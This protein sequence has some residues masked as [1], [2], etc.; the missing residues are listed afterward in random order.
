MAKS[1]TVIPASRIDEKKETK[2]RKIRVAAYCR[3]STDHEEQAGSFQNQVKYYTELIRKNLDWECAGIFADEGISGTDVRKRTGF[4][5]MI[6]ACRAGQVDLVITKSISR[7]A[8]N[9][10]D[11]LRY[12]RELKDRGIGIRFE[13]E[14]VDT[15]ASSGELLFTILSSLA[16]EESRNISENTRW[17]IRSRFKQGKAHIN[18]GRFMGYDK[19][20]NGNLIINEEQAKVVKRIFREFLEG[21]SCQE[22]SHRLIND[23]VP[24]VTGKAAWPSITIKR[25]LQNEK[26]KGDLLMQKF[27]TVDFLNKKMAKNEGALDRFYVKH[28]HEAIVSEE[29]WEAVQ[30]ELVRRESFMERHQIK[31][32]S[33]IKSMGFTGR[34]FCAACGNRFLRKNWLGNKE[35][36][37]KCI[38]ADKQGGKTCSMENLKEGDLRKAFTVA[39]NSIVSDRET[40]MQHWQEMQKS[41]SALERVR[42]KQM[43]ELTAEGLLE[44]EIPELTRM[45]LEE[46]LVHDR[47]TFTIR[48]LDG[49]EKKISL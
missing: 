34:V 17:G 41:E 16:Q 31:E 22:I 11:C 45:V 25:M 19:D 39:W 18:T 33:H 13:K 1:V 4:L 14:G 36:F 27:Y 6:E 43:I 44:F 49:M 28:A 47:K 32:G 8:R 15:M 37:W 35:A 26:Y 29:D 5:D 40:Y 38:G 3:V 24:G 23:N 48:F 21:W 7:F 12:S 2:K 20:E 9:T 30:E 42:G 10:A 46:V